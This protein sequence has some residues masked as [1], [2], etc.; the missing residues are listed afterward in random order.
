[1]KPADFR[2]KK[3]EHKMRAHKSSR[4]C[5]LDRKVGLA[6]KTCASEGQMTSREEVINWLSKSLQMPITE[7]TLFTREIGLFGLDLE[8]FFIEFAE[9]Y[10]IDMTSFRLK[11]YDSTINSLWNVWIHGEKTKQFRVD[12]LIRVIER[13]AWFDPPPPSRATSTRTPE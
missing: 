6:G 7:D 10:K 4:P 11:D 3:G 12:H 2:Q 5:G 13:G 1:M 8:A 9:H